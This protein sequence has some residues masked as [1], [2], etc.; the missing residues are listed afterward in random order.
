M[1]L[2]KRKIYTFTDKNKLHYTLSEHL[3]SMVV[4]QDG[5][6]VIGITIG[7]EILFWNSASGRLD[8]TLTRKSSYYFL[9]RKYKKRYKI[10]LSSDGFF[11]LV[12][13][14]FVGE[15]VKISIDEKKIKSVVKTKNFNNY[16]SY[17]NNF[18]QAT[19]ISPSDN[20]FLVAFDEY[21][22][23]SKVKKYTLV[24]KLIWEG[25]RTNV[26]RYNSKSFYFV[27]GSLEGSI[28]LYV[29]APLKSMW[30]IENAHN[31]A[32]TAL[33]F[34]ENTEKIIS[35]GE[36]GRVKIWDFHTG[37][38]LKELYVT[39][40]KIQALALSEDE[41]YLV[42]TLEDSVVTLVMKNLELLSVIDLNFQG[43]GNTIF[44]SLIREKIIIHTALNG[45]QMY[46]I[47]NATLI[48][49][50]TKSVYS[51]KTLTHVDFGCGARSF[52]R[53]PPLDIS[54]N[55]RYLVSALNIQKIALWDMRKIEL[56]GTFGNGEKSISAVSITDDS[57]YVFS[58]GF[59]YV[60]GYITESSIEMYEVESSLL[61]YSFE[62]DKD[63]LMVVG[64]RVT[65]DGCFLLA[66]LTGGSIMKWDI[67][68]LEL[69]ESRGI[70]CHEYD[71]YA[72]TISGDSSLLLYALD[73]SG[74]W[75]SKI[76]SIEI[77]DIA[78]GRRVD[79]I[80]YK[81]SLNSNAFLTIEISQ[82][83]RYVRLYS[84]NLERF[85]WDRV[86]KVFISPSKGHYLSNENYNNI[87]IR[88]LIAPNRNYRVN[89]YE[90]E[91][92][93]LS[94]WNLE[95][96]ELYRLFVAENNNAVIVDIEENEVIVDGGDEVVLQK[97]NE[98]E[99]KEYIQIDL[100][101]MVDK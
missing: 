63:E 2:K 98:S 58:A 59:K 90:D 5:R 86:D 52:A 39:E 45:L 6:T 64:L 94:I 75:S 38:Y 17:G 67:E 4:T 71:I 22:I 37:K 61:V 8:C 12:F 81:M 92:R 89:I 100:E 35:A 80:E 21:I 23:M 15:I 51:H 34:T 78:T 40:Q 32:V 24:K 50:F 70:S 36:D 85:C 68:S 30:S 16:N 27:A 11:A 49:E 43:D 44:T 62:I 25:N 95:N 48:Q 56:I 14:A 91:K 77:V 82:D 69:V 79:N 54:S 41:K 74:D 55:S 53:Q 46:N 65:P 99:I 31:G 42:I 96:E 97:V 83:N 84:D 10:L 101:G 19:A 9:D 3:D 20:I 88:S 93:G 28:R 1:N 57:K 73:K 72:P 13:D 7:G 66:L 33:L 87:M 60:N 29:Q 47:E 26:L 76:T 18:I